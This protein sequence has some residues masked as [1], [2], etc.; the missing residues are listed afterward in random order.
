MN[1]LKSNTEVKKTTWEGPLEDYPV[2]NYPDYVPDKPP[3]TEILEQF[4]YLDELPRIWGRRW[5][6]QGIGRLREVALVRPT[7]HEANPLWAKNPNFFLLRHSPN[8]DLDLLCK[9]HDGYAQTLR[10]CGVQVHYFEFEDVMGAYGPMRKLFIAGDIRVV[11]GG[12]LQSRFGHGSFKRGIERELQRFLARIGCPI[13]YT[14][15]GNGI[16][17]TGELYNVAEDV[18]LTMLSNAANREGLEQMRFVLERCGLKEL[19][20]AHATTLMDSFESGGEFHIDMFFGVID[21][22]KA[23][24]FPNQLDYETYKWLRSKRFDLIE[25]PPD[26]QQRYSPANLLLVEPGK[27]IMA[28]GAT[29]TIRRVE[30]A[31]VEVIAIETEGIQL[32]GVNGISCITGQLLRDPGPRLED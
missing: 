30:Q 4:S 11:R 17:E 14:V 1:P 31:G 3:R 24:I 9:H 21:L 8:I 16:F 5:G 32:G 13:L 29:E 12:A 23:I 28:K 25:I 20:V 22:R 7:E 26:E 18:M 10:D 27:V 15:C 19:H 6:S 2:E